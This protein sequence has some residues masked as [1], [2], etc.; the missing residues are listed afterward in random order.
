M[1]K[2]FS[3]LLALMLCALL[4]LTACGKDDTTA[5][6]EQQIAAL[7]QEN[8]ALKDQ[9]DVLTQQ[10]N[11]VQNAVLTDWDLTAVANADRS[12]AIISF[13]AVPAVVPE[14]QTL[15]LI[16]MRGGFEADSVLCTYE[17]GTYSCS[18]AIPAVNGYSYYCLITNP[19]GGQQEISLITDGITEDRTL[20]DLDASLSGYCHLMVEDWKFEGNTLTVNSAFF[21]AM[22]P[23]LSQD[24]SAVT[25]Q[26]A[27]LVLMHNGQEV[28]RQELTLAAGEAEGTL[29]APISGI[30]FT[31]PAL[32]DDHQLDLVLEISL[33]AGDPLR[34]NSCSWYYN[35]GE[36]TMVV[37]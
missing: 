31:V 9:I 12:G 37:G 26:K 34:N 13:T 24:G 3:A 15:S 33:S 8:A 29:E 21:Q 23:L 18:L 17:D 30:A 27:E 4:V 36:L 28:S 14:G 2:K 10:L 32:E 16:V 19:D 1:K 22:L 5:A 20:I 6:L 11:D 35:S 7:T 25:A